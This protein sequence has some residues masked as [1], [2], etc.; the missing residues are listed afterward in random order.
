VIDAIRDLSVSDVSRDPGCGGRTWTS[1]FAAPEDWGSTSLGERVQRAS[2]ELGVLVTA[3]VEQRV[4][5]LA[6]SGYQHEF[7]GNATR[8]KQS[9]EDIDFDSPLM[10][11]AAGGSIGPEEPKQ[12]G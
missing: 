1:V 5:D 6:W 3:G 4:A 11:L 7:A 10:R 12:G 2:A 8:A 9:A